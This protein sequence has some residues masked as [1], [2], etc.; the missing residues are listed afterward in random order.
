M[1]ALSFIATVIGVVL[2]LGLFVFLPMLFADLLAGTGGWLPR[3][4]IG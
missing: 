3:Y 2:A 1:A 4:G